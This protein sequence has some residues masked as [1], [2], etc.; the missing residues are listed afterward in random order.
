VAIAEWPGDLEIS[1][2]PPSR[3]AEESRAA[4]VIVD[5]ADDMMRASCDDEVAC[6]ALKEMCTDVCEWSAGC[7]GCMVTR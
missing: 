5:G 3:D 6:S 2:P 7:A 1:G 4:S